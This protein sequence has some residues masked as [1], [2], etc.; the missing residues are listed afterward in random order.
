VNYLAYLFLFAL[1][2]GLY[3]QMPLYTRYQRFDVE[4]GLPQNLVSGVVQDDD[5]FIW[6]STMDGLARF[7]GKEFLVFRHK[8]GDSTTLSSNTLNSLFIDQHN[9]LWVQ[10]ND[11]SVNQIDPR[12]F[13]ITSP[14]S[15]LVRPKA[16]YKL[17]NSFVGKRQNWFRL[18]APTND[19]Q[20]KIDLYD[21]GNR[22]LQMFLSEEIFSQKNVCAFSEDAAGSFGW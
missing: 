15:I 6:V 1:N 2:Y 7:D 10:G 16:V 19:Q 8:P 11:L 20:M 17:R 18:V 14:A 5:G 3:A 12:T 13:Q 22:K 4:N 9:K 21:T